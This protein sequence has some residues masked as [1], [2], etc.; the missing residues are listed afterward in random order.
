MSQDR[1]QATEPSQELSPHAPS[2]ASRFPYQLAPAEEDPLGN[3][4]PSPL[5]NSEAVSHNP[6]LRPQRPLD[7]CHT[8]RFSGSEL[9]GSAFINKRLMTEPPGK[10]PDIPART[11]VKGH[12]GGGRPGQGPLRLMDTSGRTL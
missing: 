10:D 4:S 2:E 5:D 12:N 3:C 11:S 7:S 9:K 6:A 1:L 8:H